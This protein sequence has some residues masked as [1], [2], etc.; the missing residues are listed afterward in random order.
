MEE[1]Q[2]YAPEE[3]I[4][5][6]LSELTERHGAY[7]E[8]LRAHLRELATELADGMRD[9]AAFLSSLADHG[10]ELDTAVSPEEAD[11]ARALLAV[12]LC[13][14]LPHDGSIRQ[15]W[16]FPGTEEI[17]AAAHNRIAYQR[18]GYTDEAFARFSTLLHDARA[19]YPH[20]FRA[21]CEEVLGGGCEFCILPLESSGEGKLHAFSTLIDT[22]GLKI[23]ATCAIPLGDGRVT[24][25]GLLRRSAAVLRP[26]DPEPRFL[27]IRTDT[28]S[29][30]LEGILTGARLCGLTL[31]RCDLSGGVLD[32]VFSPAGGDVGAFLLFL[33]LAYPHFEIVGLFRHLE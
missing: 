24:T 5:S 32:A 21:V 10:A 25:Y 30:T 11:T 14:L 4:L 27:E 19:A 1:L 12:E 13:R 28:E 7:R 3:I 6:N 26:S 15:E 17:D 16:F 2:A 23:A 33:S 22:Y 9:G 20:T 18:S 8:Q 31:S 29:G